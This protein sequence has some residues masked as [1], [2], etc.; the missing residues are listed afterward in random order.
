VTLGIEHISDLVGVADGSVVC[1]WS[2]LV[3]MC[4]LLVM[5]QIL[6]DLGMLVPV[7]LGVMAVA[8]GYDEATSRVALPAR[9]PPRSPVQHPLQLT[10]KLTANPPTTGVHSG[11]RWTAIPVLNCADATGGGCPSNLRVRGS[12]PR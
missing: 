2:W 10:A 1:S 8:V 3:S 12:R 9:T 4:P 6:G 11:R 7:Q 5:P